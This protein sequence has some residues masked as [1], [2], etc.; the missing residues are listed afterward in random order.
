MRLFGN[1]MKVFAFIS[2]IMLGV[3]CTTLNTSR[4]SKQSFFS[5]SPANQGVYVVNAG[6]KYSVMA[7]LDRASWV[8]LRRTTKSDKMRLYSAL[9]TKE[10]DIAIQDSRSF[11]AKNPKDK[12]GLV[13]LST[14]LAMSGQYKL[15]AYY[16][17]LIKKYY[18]H[19]DG[20][21]N[22]IGLAIVHSPNSNIKDYKRAMV[23]FH[24]SFTDSENK[25]ASGLNLGYLQLNMGNSEAA[26]NT[27][28]EVSRRCNFCTDSLMGQG[29]AYGRS[30]KLGKAKKVYAKILEKDSKNALA[31]YRLALIEKSGYNN[32]DGAKEYLKRILADTS[33]GNL[34]I[35]RQA[36][37]MLR[38]LDAENRT[39][40]ASGNRHKEKNFSVEEDDLYD[41]SYEME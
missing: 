39:A 31:M 40:V 6:S 23:Y 16:A 9:G 35:K 20:V 11:L 30:G 29:V 21:D 17:K 15:A 34:T 19:T 27:F 37:F 13:V 8:Q 38:K 2:F 25:V 24:K 3:S 18:P 28:G 10:W 26:I 41:V 14:A 12:D 22:I 32:N 33:D 4:S 5:K 1:V 7:K 36:N